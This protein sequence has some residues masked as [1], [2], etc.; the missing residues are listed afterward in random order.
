MTQKEGNQDGGQIQYRMISGKDAVH[1]PWEEIQNQSEQQE[2]RPAHPP[3]ILNRFPYP[4]K[5]PGGMI[6]AGNGGYCHHHPLGDFIGQI[7]LP[8]ADAECRRRTD[9]QRI[10]QRIH[11]KHGNIDGRKA[12]GEGDAQ[13]QQDL[14][15]LTVHFPA[16]ELE[17]KPEIHPPTVKKYQG[18][19]K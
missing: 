14:G 3:R 18:N 5:F 15:D 13:L 2:K 9:P 11:I 17:V 4:L 1:F 10:D 6:L 8:G 16:A 12:A 19:D 7:I